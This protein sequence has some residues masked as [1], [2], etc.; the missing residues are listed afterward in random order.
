MATIPSL[1]YYVYYTQQGTPPVIV[2]RSSVINTEGDIVFIGKNRLEYGEVFNENVLHLLENFA[3]PAIS[4][5]NETPNLSLVVPP[6]LAKPT[7]GQRWYNKTNNTVY[8]WNGVKWVSTESYEAVA[9]NSGVIFHGQQIPRPINAISGHIYEYSECTWSVSP[10]GFTDE[11]R[12]IYMECYT[13]ANGTLF[14]RYRNL[15]DLGATGGYANYQ[16]LGILDTDNHGVPP[17]TPNIPGL[18]PTPT[19]SPTTTPPVTGTAT[20]SVTPTI[21]RTPGNTPPA[22]AT[23]TVTPTLTPTLTPTATVSP[24]PT[25]TPTVTPSVTPSRVPQWSQIEEDSI[26]I[27]VS[28]GTG[29][30]CDPQPNPT[31]C[32]GGALGSQVVLVSECFIG[33]GTIRRST[34]TFECTL[35]DICHP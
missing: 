11:S 2:P 33:A 8:I 28:S 17:S 34:R 31:D 18:T 9:G 3:A 20:P 29:Q 16:I 25:I 19:P 14:M 30:P 10:F 24:T 5:T 26:L 23:P 15:G 1:R 21:S 4:S 7:K 27:P 22:S 32:N 13:D 12:V 35:Q 6:L